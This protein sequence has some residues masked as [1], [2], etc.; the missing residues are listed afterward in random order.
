MRY[1]DIRYKVSY[2]SMSCIKYKVAL[3]AKSHNIFFMHWSKQCIT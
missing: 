1:K 2:I 3:D